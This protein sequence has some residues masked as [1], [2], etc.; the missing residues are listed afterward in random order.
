MNIA[1]SFQCFFFSS[2]AFA[3]STY[4]PQ[5]LEKSRY[6]SEMLERIM[7]YSVHVLHSAGCTATGPSEQNSH[8]HTSSVEESKEIESPTS[9][10]YFP[11]K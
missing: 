4:T 9:V 11:F 10:H 3:Y 1:N 6:A 7:I 2:D 5:K 8:T